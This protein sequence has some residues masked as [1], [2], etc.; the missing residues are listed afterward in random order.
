MIYKHFQISV[1]IIRIAGQRNDLVSFVAEIRREDDD[2]TLVHRFTDA[3][4]FDS[5]N[6]ARDFA[7]DRARRWIDVHPLG[8]GSN[9]G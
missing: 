1:V 3:L 5:E 9:P 7:L 2:R 6:A 4:L 8:D